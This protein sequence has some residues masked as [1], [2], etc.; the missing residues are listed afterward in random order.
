MTGLRKDF[1]IIVYIM[2]LAAQAAAVV[3]K[4]G[5]MA[6]T[7]KRPFMTLSLLMYV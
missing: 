2:G 5:M 1:D 4:A 3:M 6:S 7:G